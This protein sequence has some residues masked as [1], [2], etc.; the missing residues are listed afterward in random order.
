[1]IKHS[2]GDYNWNIHDTERNPEND[3]NTAKLYPNTIDDELDDT[4]GQLDILSNG[5]KLKGNWN[6][7]NVAATYIFAAF[8]EVP[9]KYANAR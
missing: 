4:E 1:M 5:F 7:N 8:A 6:I 3:G 2:S 9:F